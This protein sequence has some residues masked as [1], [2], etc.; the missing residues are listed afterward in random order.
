MEA[1][2]GRAMETYIGSIADKIRD[3]AW[4]SQG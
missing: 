4:E 3:P 1:P 2:L